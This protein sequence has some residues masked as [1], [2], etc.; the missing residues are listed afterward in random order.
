M[1]RIAEMEIVDCRQCPWVKGMSKY[2]HYWYCSHPDTEGE[3]RMSDFDPPLGQVL[4]GCPLPEE[5]E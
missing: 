1:V 4:A 3:W 2:P 5:D